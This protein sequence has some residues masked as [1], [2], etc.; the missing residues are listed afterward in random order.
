MPGHG[1]SLA[2][3]RNKLAQRNREGLARFDLRY[4]PRRDIFT[5]VVKS[6][7]DL[8]LATEAKMSVQLAIGDDGFLNTSTW[9]R[10]PKGWLLTLP[11][12]P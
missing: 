12:I 11:K 9:A 4:Y 8:S 10:L 1:Q 2:Q 5:F 6:Y 3:M 7:G